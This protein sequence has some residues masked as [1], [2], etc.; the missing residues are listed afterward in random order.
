MCLCF[1]V[2]CAQAQLQ[3][4]VF[5]ILCLR[6]PMD[7]ALMTCPEKQQAVKGLLEHHMFSRQVGGRYHIFR[8]ILLACLRRTSAA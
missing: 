5:M 6:C 1:Y 2:R 3:Q 7:D 8:V 4:G